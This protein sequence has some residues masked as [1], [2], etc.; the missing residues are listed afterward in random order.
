MLCRVLRLW[1]LVYGALLALA[2]TA[3]VASLAL[4]SPFRFDVIK[5]RASLARIVDDGAIENVYRLQ[6]TNRSEREQRFRVAAHGPAGLAVDAPELRVEPAGNAN[7]VVRLRLP[8][9]SAASHA[10]ESVPVTFE[11]TMSSDAGGADARATE[12]STFLVPR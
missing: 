10:G 6:L 12:K 5:D 11:L 7:V 1:V 8:A 4:R 3:F 2:T 9:D